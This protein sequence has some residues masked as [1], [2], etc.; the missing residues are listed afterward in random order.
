MPSLW[1]RI[2]SSYRRGG[3]S[4]LILAARNA[5]RKIADSRAYQVKVSD[6]LADRVAL[7]DLAIPE[8]SQTVLDIGCNLGDVSIHCAERGLWTIGVDRSDPLVAKAM[9]R[10][11][12]VRNCAFMVMD[13]QPDDIDRFPVFDVVLLLSVHH[14]WL[15]IYGPETSAAMLRALAAK[16]G[17]VLIFEGPSR[18]ARYGDYPPDFIDNDE[19]SVTAYIESY[20]KSRV[21]DL[22]SNIRPLGRTRCVGERE[23]YRW[24][25]ALYR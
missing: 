19:D 6:S 1:N 11:R 12:G 25:Y 23:P 14:H 21:G 5:S 16:V 2:V 9:K 22:F 3:V 18:R 24:S 13:I 20:L 10:H 8:G 4:G 7:I 17:R 15:M